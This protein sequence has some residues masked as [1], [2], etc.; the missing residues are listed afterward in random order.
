MQTRQDPF[1][2]QSLDMFQMRGSA[3]SR[4]VY[5]FT[6]EVTLQIV[7]NTKVA[8]EGSTSSTPHVLYQAEAEEIWSTEVK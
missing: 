5:L 2:S 8:M 4:G 1:G 7:L 3:G 6:A